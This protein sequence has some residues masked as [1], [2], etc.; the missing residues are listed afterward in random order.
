MG[1]ARTTNCPARYTSASSE[2][3]SIIIFDI[4]FLNGSG[5]M[6]SAIS[7]FPSLSKGRETRQWDMALHSP[8]S[9]ES[10]LLCKVIN[11]AEGEEGTRENCKYRKICS[12]LKRALGGIIDF[13]RVPQIKAVINCT[14]TISH[15][16][17][18]S[19]NLNYK[20]PLYV[21]TEHQI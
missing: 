19:L 20:D 5:S 2:V 15:Q 21:V 4:H 12:V 18:F 3:Y 11:N 9:T 13:K 17:C 6:A 7:C 1:K 14:L 10:S 16:N 8:C